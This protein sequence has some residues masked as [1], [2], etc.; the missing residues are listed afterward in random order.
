MAWTGRNDETVAVLLPLLA[1]AAP[2]GAR[3]STDGGVRCAY[4]SST[5]W[6]KAWPRRVLHQVPLGAPPDEGWPTVLLF[7]G[8]SA[9]AE[10]F[11]VAPETEAWGW[12]H[13]ALVT[14]GL[15]EAGFA[16]I[17]P[18]AR[19]LGLGCWDTNLWPLSQSWERA[20][21]HHLMLELFGAIDA[22]ELGPL[23]PDRLYAAGISSG[24]Y[25]SSRVAVAYPGRF[26]AVAVHSGG[27][28]T[29]AGSLCALPEE[30]PQDHP[31]TLF[32]HGGQDHVVPIDTMRPYALALEERGVEVQVIEDGEL[33]HAWLDEAPGAL[34][35]WFVG[36]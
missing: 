8:L 27:Y 35:S 24:G 28:A 10:T 29:C 15:L 30:L 1:C 34:L 12:T 33:G 19:G 16:V 20:P 2:D 6:T 22:G 21:D 26:Q 7:Q 5:I 13:Q 31:P 17:T 3:C 14:A 9:P 25:M 4:E 23:D 11:W 18:V 32:L 36:E